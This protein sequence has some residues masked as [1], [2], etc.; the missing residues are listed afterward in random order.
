MSEKSMATIEKL[1]GREDYA[2][3]KFAVQAYLEH[4]ELWDCVAPIEGGSVDSKKDVK[5]R[6]KL[7]LLVDPMNYIHIQEAKSAKEVW[8]NLG[9]AFDDSGLTR[10]VGLLRELITTSLENCT[11]IEDYVNKIM[12]SAH[13]LR[14][15]GFEVKDEWL[16]TLL[17]T[18]L[19]DQ[20]KPML[21]A[22][23]SSGV[24]ITAD[25][26]KT[27]LLQEVK[28]SETG[29]FFTNRKKLQPI[30]QGGTSKGPRCYSCNKYGHISRNCKVKANS[31]KKSDAKCD[32][33]SFAAAFSTTINSNSGWFVD[34]GAAMHMTMNRSWLYDEVP[35]P[36]G[37]VRA[38]NN[39]EL[40]VVCCGKVNLNVT[41]KDG[42]TKL[43]QVKDV[44]YVPDLSTSL[45]SVSQIIKNKCNIK[46]DSKGCTIFNKDNVE[47]ASATLVNNMYRLNV[48]S[49][50]AFISETN[51][52]FYL[53]HQ[54][55]GHL[56]FSDLKKLEEQAEGVKLSPSTDMT[57]IS[58]IE[59]K[60]A[61][62]PF[63][64]AGSRA[65]A[66]LELVHSD[67]CGPMEVTSLGGARYFLTFIDDFSRKVCV[68]TL[69]SK[70]ECLNKFKE[71][72][73]LVE[74][75]L[76]VKIKTLRT[77][78][79]TEYTNKEFADFLRSSG[80]K[81]QTS[82]PYSPQQNG[83]AE[84]MNRTLVEKARCM[85]INANLQK[86]L[87]A[88]AVV[89]AAYIVN[90]SPTRALDWKTPEE[91][92]SGK[93]PIVSHMRVFGCEAMMHI[94]KEKVKKWDS[95]SRKMIFL[96]YCDNSKGYRL[97]DIK[98]RTVMKSRDVIFLENS[99]KRDF[100]TVPL[101]S[102]ESEKQ[103]SS[104][105]LES[106]ADD[107]SDLSTH[108]AVEHS[109]VEVTDD[110]DYVPERPIDLPER[111]NITLRPRNK[112]NAE[113][114]PKTYICSNDVSSCSV[115]QTYTEAIMSKD[116]QLWVE[117]INEELKAHDDNGTWQLV[118]KPPEAKVIGCKWVFRI[119][120]EQSG[121]RYKSRL[122]A[123][124]YAQKYGIDYTETFSP[125]VRY[126]SIRLLLSIAAEK[127]MSMMQFDV[128]TAFLY[129]E[130]HEHIY[131]TPPE[132]LTVQPNVV[133]KLKKSLYGLKQAPRCWNAK[134]NSVLKKYGFIDCHADRC[135]Y[136][137]C[138]RG[139][140][141]YLLLYVDDGLLLSLDSEVLKEVLDDLKA[142]FDIKICDSS[143]FIG[144]EIEK[145]KDYIFIHQTKYIEKMLQRFDM[146]DANP[147]SIPADPH[148]T[149]EKSSEPETDKAVP[150]R[151]AV[152]SLM[153]VAVVTRPDVMYALCTASRFLN[154]FNQTHWNAVKRVFKYLKETKRFGLCYRSNENSTIEGFSDADYANDPVTR[155]S[156]T[157]YVFM[158]NGGAVTWCSQRQPTVALSTTEA[159]FMAACCATKE[160][161]W[162]RQLMCDI[163]QYQQ[164]C[165]T[166]KI[167][168]QSTISLIKNSD[169]H[170]RCKHID[171]KYNFIKEKYA[172]KLIDL[173]YVCTD[174]QL[175]DILT[176][177][178]C[179]VKFQYFR[180]KIGVIE[181]PAVM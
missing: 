66:L 93:Q 52:D 155:R 31:N 27:K 135:V 10:R 159:E 36:V 176:K 170:K 72:K 133:C 38:A 83:L 101:S 129:G 73:C 21:M 114:E 80:I 158:K 75:Q 70:S 41:Q 4:E 2:S 119:K 139:I 115:P 26:V 43:I 94:P 20:Y 12:T 134:F 87:W 130:L 120:D 17:L 84:R 1:K 7:I 88:E 157:G 55:M 167:D 64:S 56:N 39:K 132:G 54:R 50:Q 28:S 13:K 68:F 6:S 102:P 168:N 161:L 76:N 122:C 121:P 124:G 163:G 29:V 96:G 42:T 92:W 137:S 147:I 169:F 78:N 30:K 53:W 179:R 144:I 9:K 15:I 35:P 74:N 98:S 126:D 89:T 18:G 131:M 164:G 175:A 86:Y 166:L 180:K 154:S 19:P 58:C 34:S 174:N 178:L 171:V 118:E 100:V 156:T 111:S 181:N 151:E 128:K 162:I 60:Q 140:K 14:N 149:L 77:D 8:T 65:S 82:T 62:L 112:K 81:H 177:A 160:A 95:R 57:C 45:L 71:Y 11:S 63:T 103:V 51:D 106:D 117:S 172:Q 33:N 125:T 99:V 165:M 173:Q 105:V 145:C 108:T 49:V 152:G 32:S 107:N 44:L 69:K 37:S 61:R 138:F 142:N 136:V 46:F 40:K 141:V 16:G 123:K 5:A 23:E 22:L 47:V 153:Y 150:F 48:A 110:P 109:E 116:S 85:L 24:A 25:L 59:G 104:D 91:K 146:C 67:V 143:N 113:T 148:V 3:W 79:G 97:L 127:G 90:R